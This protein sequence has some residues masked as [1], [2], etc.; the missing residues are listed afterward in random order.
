[1]SIT[2]LF[3][4]LGGLALFL[5][6]M[7]LMSSAL[8]LVAGNKMN[9]VIEKLTS[10]PIKGVL[11]GVVVTAI[12][13]SSSATTVMVVGFVNAGL[14]TIYQAAGIIMGANIGTTI[15]GQLVALN[16]TKSAPI[17][18]FIGF[19]MLK[20]FKK[21]KP[22][23]FGQVLIG[24]G[25]LFMGMEFMSSSMAPLR[26]EPEFIALMTKFQNPFLGILAGTTITAAIQA[27]A[28][29]LGILQAIANQGLISLTSSMYIV[30]GFNIGTCITSVLSAI[31]TSKNAQ[32]TAAVHVLFNMIGTI[33]FVALSFV[34]PIDR[35]IESISRN[36]PAAQIANMHTFFNLMT[37]ILLFPFS[38]LLAKLAINLIRGKDQE[39]EDL[40][41]K[42]INDRKFTDPIL[43]FTNVRAETT[44]MFEIAKENFKLSM[45]IFSKYDS[46]KFDIIF[47]N[48]EILNYL[49]SQITKY[50]IDIMGNP[51][52][53]T[54]ASN[55]TGYM[56]IVRD[57][58]RIGDH[59]K[60]IADNA[61][62]SVEREL[63]YSEE[64]ISEID[65]IETTIMTMFNTIDEDLEKAERINRLRFFNQKVENYTTT[66]RNYHMERM[67]TGDCD[68]ESGLI[69]EKVLIALER[70]S[71]YLSNSGKLAV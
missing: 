53:D 62:L 13:Q 60:S 57:I 54:L 20:G 27:S 23:Y 63:K 45:E 33:I 40:S 38:K 16:I 22:K 25:F 6:G 12:I 18:A 3:G 55:F 35:F 49:N 42:Y 9:T 69:F 65:A 48:E 70:I 43:V 64:S 51:M 50:I 66:Y 14:M 59:I 39:V 4:L 67:K 30:C 21:D 34:I 11:V 68:P 19:C 44:R 46:D 71:S 61:K 31:G 29:S 24:L 7:D 37:T 10:N 36:L 32:R 26:E 41:L 15:T 58:E 28:A 17:I 56:R 47:R 52:E 5:F 1:M 8:E 2:Y